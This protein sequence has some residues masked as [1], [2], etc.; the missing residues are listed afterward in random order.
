MEGII[1]F[2]V[3]QVVD[4]PDILGDAHGIVFGLLAKWLTESATLP[5]PI[6]ERLAN[7]PH[8]MC[9]LWVSSRLG[10]GQPLYLS[11][12]WSWPSPNLLD[13]EETQSLAAHRSFQN[14]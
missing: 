3:N 8:I 2:M 5:K 6:G 4:V 1:S 7:M 14:Q 12:A 9:P 10:D 13:V 11:S